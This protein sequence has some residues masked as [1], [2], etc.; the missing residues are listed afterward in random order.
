MIAVVGAGWWRVDEQ[1]YRRELAQAEKEY[2]LREGAKPLE[3]KNSPLA[4]SE[5]SR[6]RE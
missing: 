5:S 6:P 4:P 1:R 3:M 2:R